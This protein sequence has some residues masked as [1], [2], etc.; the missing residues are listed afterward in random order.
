[1]HLPRIQG[2]RVQLQQVMLNLI[3]NAIE[4]MSQMEEG[5][6]Q[7][8]ISTATEADCVLVAVRDSG[9]SVSEAALARVFEAFYT[10]KSTGLG[11][12]LSIC[13]AIVEAHDGRMWAT[14]NV[15]QGA[16]FRFTLPVRPAAS[17]TNGARRDG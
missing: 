17:A 12:G 9:P 6:R 2:D 16:V 5:P 14:P 11:M 1:E 7:I 3:I 4:A 13:A 8:V 15:P 10:T